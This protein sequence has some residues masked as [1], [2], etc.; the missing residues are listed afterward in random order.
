MSKTKETKLNNPPNS[1]TSRVVVVTPPLETIS[2]PRTMLPY[3]EF[4]IAKYMRVFIGKRLRT[5]RQSKKLTLIDAGAMI[6]I[7]PMQLRRYEMGHSQ[8]KGKTLLRVAEA[9]KVEPFIIDVNALLGKFQDQNVIRWVLG[10]FSTKYILDAY[11]QYLVDT[12]KSPV[13]EAYTQEDASDYNS[14]KTIVASTVAQDDNN[15]K[16]EKHLNEMSKEE[17]HEL[18][19]IEQED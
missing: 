8:L 18:E 12:K 14:D 2:T 13:E 4:D 9:Y 11:Q 5:I 1:L 10:Q 16:I 7:F 3:P 6:G 19:V 15:E 17:R